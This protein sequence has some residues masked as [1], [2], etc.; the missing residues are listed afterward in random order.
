MN[1]ITHATSPLKLFEYMAGHKP[2]IV[3]AMHESG[4]L[5]GVLTARTADQFVEQIDRALELQKNAAF[6]AKI[7]R[8]ARENTWD[9]R[10][11]QILQVLPKQGYKSKPQDTKLKI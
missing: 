9:A 7:D 10:A 8:V 1:D 11:E 6:I 3:T 4:R 2:V 5:E